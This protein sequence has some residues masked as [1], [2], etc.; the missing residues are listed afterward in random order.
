MTSTLEQKSIV[1]SHKVLMHLSIWYYQVRI[2]YVSL[3]PGISS[4]DEI[5]V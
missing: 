5:A 3:I 1:V 4:S 2:A